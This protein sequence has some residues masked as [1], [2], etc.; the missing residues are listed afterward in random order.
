MQ[1]ATRRVQPLK[2]HVTAR[3]GTHRVLD[4]AC[5]HGVIL[6]ERIDVGILRDAG[7]RRV[8]GLRSRHAILEE[9][10][11]FG[12]KLPAMQALSIDD[13]GSVGSLAARPE[14]ADMRSSKT[15]C[16]AQ[17]WVSVGGPQGHA[18]GLCLQI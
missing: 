14:H 7:R 12:L 15:S 11:P 4:G 8:H 18:Q 6:L 2:S 5:V 10:W 1:H 3:Y 16:A 17:Q 13:G 9:I